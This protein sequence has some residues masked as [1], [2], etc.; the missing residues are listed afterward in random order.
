MRLRKRIRATRW[1]TV[2]LAAAAIAA[3]GAQAM[4]VSDDGGVS[5]GQVAVGGGNGASAQVA[6]TGGGNGGSA[7]AEARRD[8]FSW[9]SALLAGSALAALGALGAVVSRRPSRRQTATLTL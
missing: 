6:G 3:P 9:S 5:A 1:I 8:G 4:A 7:G 2:A